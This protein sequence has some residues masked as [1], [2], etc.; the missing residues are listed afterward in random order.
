[1]KSFGKQIVS[2]IREQEQSGLTTP[3]GK[4]F[5]QFQSQLGKCSVQIK[6]KEIGSLGILLDSVVMKRGEAVLD[7]EEQHRRLE[8]MAH[9]VQERLTYL[10][11]D[12]RLLELDR[13]NKKAQL[14]SYP[15]HQD[16]DSKYYYEIV[17]DEAVQIHF[18]RYQFNR[19]T[20]RYEKIAS[21]L[22]L[23]VFERLLDDLWAILGS[24]DSDKV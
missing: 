6:Y 14:R 11:E 15:P 22:T 18:Q 13:L 8:K 24:C 23:E 21:Q 17:I 7:L 3:S 16:E 4:K 10:L 20:R 1:M 19:K 12:F 9:E 5:K 2:M